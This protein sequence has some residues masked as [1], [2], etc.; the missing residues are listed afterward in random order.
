M[1]SDI[2][3]RLPSLEDLEVYAL[4]QWEVL[5]SSICFH[6]LFTCTCFLGNLCLQLLIVHFTDYTLVIFYFVKS[7]FFA[8]TYKL[9]SSWKAI[10]YKPFYDESFPARP[11]K[12]KVTLSCINIIYCSRIYAYFLCIHK[13]AVSHIWYGDVYVHYYREKEAPRLTESGFQFLVCIIWI[14]ICLHFLWRVLI[15]ISFICTNY[16]W[17][18]RMHNFG[19]SSESTSLILR[20]E[21]VRFSFHS[22]LSHFP[23]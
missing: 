10:K 18:T 5:S 21:I 12:S 2:T 8:P 14:M 1:P 19:T 6:C 13:Y 3:V 17:W 16:S 20:Y 11:F 23:W 9:G 15:E 7:V 4:A 22:S